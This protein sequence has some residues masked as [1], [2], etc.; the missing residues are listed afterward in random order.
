MVREPLPLLDGEL[1]VSGL[2]GPVEVLFDGYAVPH[3]Y[4]RDPDDAWF[5]AGVLHARERLWQMEIYRRVTAGRL[6]EM[7]G[8][9][10]P[11]P[12]T[13]DS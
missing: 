4:A 10:R 9:G 3:V 2:K 12:S 5:T 6:S 8:R 1:G 11:C 13:S 7:F